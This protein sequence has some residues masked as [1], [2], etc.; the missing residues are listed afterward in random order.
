MMVAKNNN[1]IRFAPYFKWI[2]WEIGGGNLLSI[3]ND[4]QKAGIIK[5]ITAGKNNLKKSANCNLLLCH[6]IKVVISPNGLN[7]PPALAATTILIQAQQINFLLSGAT[8]IT[9][10]DISNAVVKLSA[11]GEIKNPALCPGMQLRRLLCG[12]V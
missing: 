2:V 8:A 10:A 6:T 7:A 12:C 1:S 9:I 11:T 5:L 4:M 3:A